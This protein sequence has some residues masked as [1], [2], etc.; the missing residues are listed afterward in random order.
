[1]AEKKGQGPAGDGT[2]G[3]LA[4][5]TL[6]DQMAAE[7][8]A[9]DRQDAIGWEPAP[10]RASDR[11]EDATPKALSRA[12]ARDLGRRIRAKLSRKG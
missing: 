10:P 7:K 8:A 6:A 1:M 2:K 4:A 3:V 5:P 11:P 12:Q 9:R